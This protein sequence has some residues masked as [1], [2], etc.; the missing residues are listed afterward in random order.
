LKGEGELNIPEVV[1]YRTGENIWIN[2]D[3]W[4][5][6]NSI[7]SQ[8]FLAN[9]GKLILNKPLSTEKN[10]DEFLSDPNKPVPYT[11]KFHDSQQMY[12]RTYMSEDQRFA[13]A[14]PDV[15]VYESEPLEDKVTIA[16][17]IIADLFVSTSGTDADWIVKV[18]DVYPD[19][20][21][22]PNPN[23][24][25]IELGGY[26]RMIRFEIMRGKFRNSYQNPEPFVP[27]Q[28]TN[29]KVKLQDV[30]HTF[31]KGHK[32]MVQIQSSMFPLFDRNPQKFV[33]IYNAKDEDFQKAFH[34]VYFSENNQSSIKFTLVK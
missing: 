27:N 17:P 29:V 21:K 12:Y 32:I 9:N 2:H 31:L 24:N 14:R 3:A 20:I 11:G 33:D 8:L 25:N 15:L 23:P 19:S 22:N 4:I 16:G 26:Q 10:Y 30:D 28:P 34:R 13:S 6:Q 7:S 5:P 1:T 18:I